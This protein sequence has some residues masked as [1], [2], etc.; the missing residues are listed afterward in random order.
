[1]MKYG[2]KDSERIFYYTRYKGVK[3]DITETDL[4]DEETKTKIENELE[5]VRRS[6]VLQ[7]DQHEVERKELMD[8]LSQFEQNKG[9]QKIAEILQR[10]DGDKIVKALMKLH[11]M[12]K[13]RA[14]LNELRNRVL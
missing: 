4:L 6:L 1:M 2:W 8:R 5:A 12:T 9:L 13:G 14:F 3:D 7:K 10:K 11:E